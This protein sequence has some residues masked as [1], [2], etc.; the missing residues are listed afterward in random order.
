[1]K[2]AVQ[3][4]GNELVSKLERRESLRSASVQCCCRVSWSESTT[5]NAYTQRWVSSQENIVFDVFARRTGRVYGGPPCNIYCTPHPRCARYADPIRD[6]AHVILAR[7]ANTHSRLSTC[8][9]ALISTLPLIPFIGSVNTI[10]IKLVL[11]SIW[12]VTSYTK[13]FRLIYESKIR[14]ASCCFNS[15]LASFAFLCFSLA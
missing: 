9:I 14:G 7:L 5:S 13:S 15:N 4:A 10:H 8:M 2:T 12:S 6:R 11:I 1:M 3:S